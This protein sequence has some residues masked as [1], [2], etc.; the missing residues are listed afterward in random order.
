[1]RK[2]WAYFIAVIFLLVIRFGVLNTNY[3][4]WLLSLN[5][6]KTSYFVSMLRNSAAFQEFMGSWALI[7]YIGAVLIFWAT[8]EDDSGI[9]MQFLLLPIAYVPFSIIGAILMNAEFRFNYLWI[10]PLIILPFGY[11][12]VSLWTILIWLFDKLRILKS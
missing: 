1:M 3:D 12:Y 8:E 5:Y 9:P 11:L 6:Q 7:F 10:H 4:Q 2:K